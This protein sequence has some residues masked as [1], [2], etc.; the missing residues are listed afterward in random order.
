MVNGIGRVVAI[1]M[2]KALVAPRKRAEESIRGKTAEE[3][4][5]E[6]NGKSGITLLKRKHTGEWLLEGMKK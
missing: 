3:K 4:D 5:E 1:D 2:E 6:G